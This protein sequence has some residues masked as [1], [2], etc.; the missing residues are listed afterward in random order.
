MNRIIRIRLDVRTA[1]PGILGIPTPAVLVQYQGQLV[2]YD[3]ALVTAPSQGQQVNP[4][5]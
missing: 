5:A 1:Y 4:N 2:T 3:G